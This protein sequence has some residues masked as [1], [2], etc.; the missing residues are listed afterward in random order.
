VGLDLGQPAADGRVIVF[1]GLVTPGV[2]NASTI[3]S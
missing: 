1:S 2:A 3:S